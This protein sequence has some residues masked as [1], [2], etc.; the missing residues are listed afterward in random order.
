MKATRRWFFYVDPDDDLVEVNTGDGMR[1]RRP[2]RVLGRGESFRGL[3]FEELTEA[4]AGYIQ[5]TASGATIEPDTRSIRP[6]RF[7]MGGHGLVVERADGSTYIL[8]SARLNA[9]G[10][11]RRRKARS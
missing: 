4:R 1:W 7:I 5:M 10:T 11:R 3:T 9:D 6:E 8:R 2:L